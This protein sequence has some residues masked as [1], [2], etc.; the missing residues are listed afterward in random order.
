MFLSW[1]QIDKTC[2]CQFRDVSDNFFDS[3]QV[4]TSLPQFYQLQTLWV[5]IKIPI[6]TSFIWIWNFKFYK[7]VIL[8]LYV[9][10]R[11]SIINQ[12]Y[13]KL[14]FFLYALDI[15]NLMNIVK[16]L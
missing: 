1:N 6:K 11:L 3:Q 8:M 12:V 10:I 15:K 4:P 16:M 13:M 5:H 9:P 14:V 2:S 7:N